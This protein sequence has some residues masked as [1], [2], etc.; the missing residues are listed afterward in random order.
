MRILVVTQY[1][2]PESF[3]VNGLVAELGKRGHSIEV[4]TGLP[5]YPSGS[6]TE[7]YSLLRGPW[8][9]TYEG[10]KIHRSFLIARGRGFLR[11][12]LNYI[13]FV[14][15]GCVKALLLR[16][17]LS[18]LHKNKYDV[19]F[20]YAPSP[21]T[22]CL[23]AIFMRWLTQAP[24]I[25][26]VQDLWPES[27]SAV[28]AIKSE[29]MTHLFGKL[30]RFIY[31]RC[32]VILVP[33]KAFKSS[34]LKWGGDERKIHYLPNWAEPFA[35]N[36]AAPDWVLNLPKGFKIGFA[37]NIGKAQDMATLVTAAELLKEHVDIRW[38]VVGDGSEKAWLE[39][40]IK[41]RGLQNNITTVGKKPYNE[42]LPFFKTCDALYVSL[43]NDFI[44]SLTVPS[45]VQ[46]YLSAARPIVACL[47]GEGA[48]IVNEARAGYATAAAD[49]AALAEAILKLKGL[50]VVQREQ[51]GING[52]NYFKEHFERS[53]V[54]NKIEDF[55]L[56]TA[57]LVKTK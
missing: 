28:G 1:F 55:I 40:E 57:Q 24:L 12:S 49:P 39:A 53:I 23:P 11:L 35:E 13:S 15:G 56:K 30:V 9:E 18:K 31:R 38:I 32:D 48:H 46:A 43:T 45:K 10:A 17:L 41:T 26:W 19:I 29:K 42:M 33:S 50:P 34:I 16:K 47:N 37:G 21:V 4:L 7:G 14:L 25:F 3:I 6:L 44:F 27:I 54:I 51:M 8:V 20:C 36:Q 52:L 22:A 5:N 2:W